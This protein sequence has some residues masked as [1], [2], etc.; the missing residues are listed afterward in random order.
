MSTVSRASTASRSG[1][2]AAKTDA[3][4]LLK[5]DHA[6]VKKLFKE[7]DAAHT[8]KQ[9]LDLAQSICRELTIHATVEEELFYPAVREAMAA[10]DLMDEAEVEHQSA[11]D[12]IAQIEAGGPGEEMWEARV[13]VLGEYIKHHV[14]EEETEMFPKVRKADLDLEALGE[15]MAG[16]KAELMG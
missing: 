15:R 12:L 8:E 6:A 7:F 11:K 9:K 2:V 14:K 10:D 5:A 4:K 16:R 13:V 3:I 1:K